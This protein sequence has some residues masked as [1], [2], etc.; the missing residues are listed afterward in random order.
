MTRAVI[1]AAGEGTRLRPLTEQLP[2]AL[3]P[4]AGATL[5]DRQLDVLGRA[6]ITDVSVVTG[7]ARVAF[8]GRGLRLFDNPAYAST[9]MVA[10]LRCAAAVFDGAE[11]VVIAYG[12]IVYEPR[13]LQTL[14]D[15]DA[16][17]AVVVDLGWERLWRLRMDDPL[18]DAETMKLDAQ[19]RIVELGRKP[20]SLDDIQ[21]Q[22][23]GLV[24]V[25][26]G[27]ASRFFSIYDGMVAGSVQDGRPKEKMY[28]TSYLQA[29]IDAAVP[30]LA[31]KV[32]NGWLEL[33]STQ[34]LQRY[35]RALQ[36]GLLASVYD[37]TT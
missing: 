27:F 13:V 16:P 11:D 10:S 30:V 19:G 3:V 20:R 31:A 26:R 6:G 32:T 28:M 36:Q 9:N 5:L 4:F 7:H 23:I 22:Y 21:G 35:E 25:G 2:K 34:D 24:K 29:H 8:W 18:S 12:D 33:D 37:G 15:R 1:L 14:L 17:I